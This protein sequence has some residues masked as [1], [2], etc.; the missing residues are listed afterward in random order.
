MQ[1]LTNNKS[2]YKIQFTCDLDCCS[3]AISMSVDF[4]T[5]CCKQYK[6]FSVVSV[7]IKKQREY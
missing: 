7:L 6:L 1:H 5:F 2:V 4:D 3:F